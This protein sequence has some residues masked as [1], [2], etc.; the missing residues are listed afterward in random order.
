MPGSTAPRPGPCRPPSPPSTF[1]HSPPPTGEAAHRPGSGSLP[2]VC[3]PG[4]RYVHPAHPQAA[5]MGAPR[6]VVL[7]R[8][9]ETFPATAFPSWSLVRGAHP[10]AACGVLGAVH[11]AAP[12]LALRTRRP[13][14]GLTQAVRAKPPAQSRR[15]RSRGR[16][17]LTVRPAV[18]P[19]PSAPGSRRP[20]APFAGPAA[21][22]A[23][24]RALQQTPRLLWWARPPPP[25]LARRFPIAPDFSW[26]VASPFET[27][28]QS[29]TSFA[30]LPSAPSLHPRTD[31][32]CS[33]SPSH[34][35]LQRKAPR[36]LAGFS[37][38]PRPVPF[39]PPDTGVTRSSQGR[40]LRL[41][42]THLLPERPAHQ[43][44][45]CLP[46]S[47]CFY[48]LIVRSSKVQFGEM[49]PPPR[50]QTPPIFP[51]RP[52]RPRGESRVHTGASLANRGV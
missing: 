43:R 4:A 40:W 6:H 26:P 15:C 8:G 16:R 7:P 52:R 34:P 32:S 51:L 23:G 3:L 30:F 36:G 22:A 21:L 5:P 37:C 31:S 49:Q 48:V 47:P 19:R 39:A 45:H 18:S 29:L 33:P 24:S 46:P 2:G 13:L 17:G 38:R 44:R 10:S 41:P 9:S 14:W 1:L 28:V 11:A 35:F 12:V 20:Q 25:A 42:G 50:H 27:A